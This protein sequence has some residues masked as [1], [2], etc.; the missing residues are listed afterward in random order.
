MAPLARSTATI[1]VPP[2]PA[3]VQDLPAA[4]KRY[5]RRCT[6]SPAPEPGELRCKAPPA[7]GHFEE[8][9]AE[10]VGR[11]DDEPWG[12]RCPARPRTRGQRVAAAAAPEIHH[13]ELPAGEVAQHGAVGRPERPGGAFGAF[14]P[15]GVRLSDPGPDRSRSSRLSRDEREPSTVGR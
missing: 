14:D 5:G 2:V 7:A 1:L 6:D 8:R 9:D 11:E 10:K 15:A 12:S 13:P 4:G 3:A